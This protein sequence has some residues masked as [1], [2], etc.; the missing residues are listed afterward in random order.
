ML[1]EGGCEGGGG[2]SDGGGIEVKGDLHGVLRSL[3]GVGPQ[4]CVSQIA[5]LV[6]NEIP[7][8]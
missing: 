2:R 4:S 6:D 1:V 3:N 8:R 7:Q 5:G